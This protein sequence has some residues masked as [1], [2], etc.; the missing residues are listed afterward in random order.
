MSNFMDNLYIAWTIASKDITGALK[1]KSSRTN[2]IL[3]IGIVVFFY[4]A[5]T[6]RP[7][8]KRIDVAIYDENN[9]SLTTLPTQLSEGYSF[10]FYEASSVGDMEGQMGYKQLGVVI[11]ADFD[12]TLASEGEPT[13]TGYIMWE[14]RGE[15]AELEAKYSAMFTELLG[16]PVQLEIGE[17]FVI[18]SPDVDAST[19]Q[20]TILYAMLFMAISVVPAL[21]MEEKQTKTMDALLVSPASA[22][23]VV[24]G[25]A[26]AGLFFVILGGGLFFVLHWVYITNWV[27]AFLAFLF[28]AM[29]SIV[30][31]LVMGSFIETQQ[32]MGIWTLPVMVFLI[33][34]A[35][36]SSEPNLAPG[37]RTAFS[38]LPSSA[39]SKIFKFSMSSSAPADQLLTNLA[40][41]GL[42]T[43]L[44]FAVVIWKVRRSDR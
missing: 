34:P 8:D 29:F 35:F 27:L 19:V 17:N 22:G 40:V 31:A 41:V 21:M 43:A 2:I 18:P 13:L 26:L 33:V 36:F 9:S 14:H 6:P 42:S 28:C 1:N 10:R 16:Q 25:K 32:Q 3:V 23:Q 37:L 30:L 38:W 24:M 12:Q 11:P 39:V 7:F 4:W 5:S 20:F 15:T 44:L